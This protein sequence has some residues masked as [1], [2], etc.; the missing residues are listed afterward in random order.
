[1]FALQDTTTILGV[2]P[3]VRLVLWAVGGLIIWGIGRQAARAGCGLFGL[4]LGG[5]AV[6]AWA[7][8]IGQQFGAPLWVMLLA[9]GVAAYLLGWLMF[10]ACVGMLCAVLAACILPIV[11]LIWQQPTIPYFHPQMAINI[12]Q[13][14]TLTHARAKQP[15]V[16]IHE[17]D[18]SL[19]HWQD[20]SE[21]PFIDNE[22]ADNVDE[23]TYIETRV[24]QRFHEKTVELID[25]QRQLPTRDRAQ[26]LLMATLGAV[27]GL[28][29][30]LVKP[31][32]GASLMS[33]ILGAA[34]MWCSVQLLIG[35]LWTTS[36]AW[37]SGV[38]PRVAS[39]HL[40]VLM[41]LGVAVQ[42]GMSRTNTD[43]D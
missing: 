8:P 32:W 24:V 28:L 42:A 10:R 34:L 16:S 29:F 41:L 4:V 39:I 3:I 26:L 30:G 21:N 2:G 13:T 15:T 25:W 20:W 12:A 18:P 23:S 7:E 31:F 22:R 37:L 36:P 11:T 35:S 6:L 27:L 9:A 38:D 40:G 14:S 43:N 19:T 5:W 33:A 1:M 17:H